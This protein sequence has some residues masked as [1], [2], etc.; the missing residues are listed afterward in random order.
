MQV[1][2]LV[3]ALEDRNLLTGPSWFLFFTL[4][5]AVVSSTMFVISNKEDPTAQ[6]YFLA[7]QRGYKILQKFA[8][9]NR[10]AYNFAES[11]KV[12]QSY[13]ALTISQ[14]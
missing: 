10:M 13:V 12:S 1:I 6:E 3:E 2:W 9:T 14:H 11:L 8:G 5:V 7:A 4:F